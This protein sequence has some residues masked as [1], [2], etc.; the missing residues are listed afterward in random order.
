MY[1]LFYW[2]FFALPC[3]LP[4]YGDY[5]TVWEVRPLEWYPDSVAR[6]LGRRP[7]GAG[8]CAG[9]RDPLI[10]SQSHLWASHTHQSHRTTA[11][12][13]RTNPPRPL[14][15]RARPAPEW[16]LHGADTPLKIELTREPWSTEGRTGLPVCCS[17]TQ[18]CLT[19]CDPMDRSM[20]GFP[21]PSSSPWVY[22]D[23]CPVSLWCCLTIF[24]SKLEQVDHHLDT[25]WR[26]FRRLSLS[27]SQLNVQMQHRIIHHTESQENLTALMG[28]IGR[29]MAAPR[30]PTC[31]CGRPVAGCKAVTVPCEVGQVLRDEWKDGNSQ[32][33]SSV[34]TRKEHLG[35][36]RVSSEWPH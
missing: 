29:Q 1:G 23:S 3:K 34:R 11:E 10:L 26:V 21:C 2:Y 4:G 33:R 32:Q 20:P 25:L 27:Q 28:K 22:S 7:L 12:A 14:P 8:E 17:V 19:L 35:Q 18:T 9:Q 13:Q 6:R 15:P 5:R 16:R 31:W 30:W 24:L 36:N